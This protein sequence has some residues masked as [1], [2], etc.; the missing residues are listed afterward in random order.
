MAAKRATTGNDIVFLGKKGDV[1]HAL[2]GQD[3]VHGG[4]GNDTLFGDDDGDTLYGESGNDTLFGGAG[5]DTLFGGAGTNLL[6]GGAGINTASFADY[7]IADQP[8][9]VSLA[10]GYAV[11]QT[12]SGNGVPPGLGTG[13]TFN[14]TLRGIQNVVG[15]PNTNNT[16]IGDNANNVLTGGNLADRIEG[17]RGNDQIF[18]S[19]GDDYIVG[20]PDDDLLNG[21]QGADIFD[22]AFDEGNLGSDHITGF[23]LGVDSLVQTLTLDPNSSVNALSFHLD[24]IGGTAVAIMQAENDSGTFFATAYFDGFSKAN[25]LDFYAANPGATPLVDVHFLI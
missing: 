21:G 9:Y 11:D 15:A 18:G 4:D 10:A 16:I 25:I 12:T 14:D 7:V 17:D 8:V 3:E 2:A 5:D 22:Y 24:E 20:G 13:Q 19:N 6:D 23:E 1:F